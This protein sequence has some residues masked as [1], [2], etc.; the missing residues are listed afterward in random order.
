M[1]TIDTGE[2]TDRGKVEL[3]RKWLG[4]KIRAAIRTAWGVAGDREMWKHIFYSVM[5]FLLPITWVLTAVYIWTDGNFPVREVAGMVRG[6]MFFIAIVAFLLF[7]GDP[8]SSGD[9]TEE[10]KRAAWRLTLIPAIWKLVVGIVRAIRR[11]R[12]S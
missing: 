8:L 2:K 11:W 1:E 3:A 7:L 9:L 4:K 10:Y 12:K 5:I 6:A